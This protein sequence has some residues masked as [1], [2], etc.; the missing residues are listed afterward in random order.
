M[1]RI[2]KLA[3]GVA[4]V[5]VG[6]PTETE[7]KY[8]KDKIDDAVNATRAAVE[9][10]IVPGGGSALAKI[11]AELREK[12]AKKD[13]F[14]NQQITTNSEYA[15]GY[16]LMLDA[17]SAPLKQIAVNAGKDG[18]VVVNDVIKAESGSG[19]NAATDEVVDMLKEGIIDPVKVTRS[20][21]QHAA[22]A[23]AIFLTSEV[24]IADE[25]KD[26]AEAPMGGGMP[27]GMGMP[28]MG[29]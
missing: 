19:Y 22:S 28:G 13:E 10:G 21:V 9:E 17:L 4:V 29:M 2:A 3:G 24:A 16:S 23:A 18:A 14:L 20:G 7:M 11:S 25:P 5:R 27:G 12:A 26:E 6:A 1:K 15:I 8:L